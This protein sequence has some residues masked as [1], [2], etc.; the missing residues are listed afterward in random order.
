M[1]SFQNI[2]VGI[3]L[4]HCERLEVA[5]LGPITCSALGLARWVARRSGGRLTY[6][7]A[8]NKHA[9]L[10]DF[11][12]PEH[13]SQLSLAVGRSVDQ[14]LQQLAGQDRAE[15]S[16]RT[17]LAPGRGWV[18][19]IHQ[20]IRDQHDLVVVGSRSAGN[21]RTVLFG[22]TATRLLRQC[23]CPVS[24][25]RPGLQDGPQRVLV[26][27]DLGPAATEA[28]RLGVALLH[29]ARDIR[30]HVLHAIENPLDRLW[31]TGVSDAW[32]E[33]YRGRLRWAAEETIRGQLEAVG[34]TPGDKNLQIHIVDKMGLPDEAILQFIH[35]Q[36]ID[37]LVLGT[38]A[39]SGLASTFLGNT[40]ERLLPELCCSVLVVKP[41]GFQCP[42]VF[43]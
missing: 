6:L 12:D 37:L 21:L 31:S 10:W 28:L 25:V 38:A 42:M 24:V 32:T 36:T 15:G 26:A 8:L 2:L 1:T 3:D 23:P 4:T 34:A 16:V 35:D 9:R 17:V 20:V 33:A 19:L 14:V 11:I 39:R 18:E 5:S 27:T 40:A 29:L 22:S 41:P 43:E 30:L 7:S 13:R